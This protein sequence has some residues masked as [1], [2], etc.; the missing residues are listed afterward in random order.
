MDRV[1]QV[2]L[3]AGVA[4]G[5][6]PLAYAKVLI[7]LGYEPVGPTLHT[8]WFGSK[9]LMYPNV[10][11]YVGYIKKT[12]GFIGM[13]R[14][15]GARLISA[16]TS[17]LVS[18]AVQSHLVGKPLAAELDVSS[19]DKAKEEEQFV[20]GVKRLFKDTMYE[21]C[22]RCAGI[23][24]SQPFH[25][26]FVRSVAQFIGRETKYSS[27]SSSIQE[28]WE[29]DGVLGFFAGLIPRLIGEALTIWLVNI[30][31]HAINNYL[32]SDSC[33]EDK[34]GYTS[35][36][37]H[38]LVSQITYPFNVVA[39]V[40]AVNNSGLYAGNPPITPIYTDWVDCW[41]RLSKENQLK[42]GSS[43]FW[44]TYKGPSIV[45]RAGIIMPV[46]ERPF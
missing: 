27:I 7:Q 40:M 29:K 13:Y 44:R 34:R 3:G 42:R 32:L 39:N 10:L 24:V 26:I 37:S 46:I 8:G 31:T 9:S 23:V 45:N 41:N 30:L 14:G 15:L 43:V 2:V 1:P 33:H 18:N 20:E 11:S 28:I 38:L 5:F 22:S 35:M 19:R 21:T 6:H 17:N 12:D 4:V 16:M 36:F 25:V